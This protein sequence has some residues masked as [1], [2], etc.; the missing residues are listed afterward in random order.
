MTGNTQGFEAWAN[1][2]IR[3]WWRLSA[4]FAALRKDL[5]LVGGAPDVFGVAFAGNDPRQQWQVRSNM[6]L[7]GRFAVDLW[8]RRVGEL[9]SPAIPAY[10]EADARLTWDASDKLELSI[11]GH[12]LL[13]ARHLEFINQSIPPSEIPRSFTLNA[14]WIH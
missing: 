13:Q 4:G 2:A 5:R 1:Y 9:E 11:D 8:L 3:E 12:N 10:L 7:P 14:R 6:D